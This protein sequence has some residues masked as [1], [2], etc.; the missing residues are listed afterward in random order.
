MILRLILV[1]VVDV[2]AYQLPH[3]ARIADVG[4]ALPTNYRIGRKQAQLQM[5]TNYIRRSVV[6]GN[7][8]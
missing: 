7:G 4:W 5:S 8:L 3:Q 1:I 2:T 6:R